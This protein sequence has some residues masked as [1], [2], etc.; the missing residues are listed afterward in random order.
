[1][2]SPYPLDMAANEVH[3]LR[4][5]GELFRLDASEIL[6]Q[7]GELTG[8][9][10]LDLCCGVG[11]V[12]D[13]LCEAVG[14]DGEVV[15]LD[16]DSAKLA[17]ARA[18][19]PAPNLV[20]IEGD[21]FAPPLEAASFDLVHSRFAMGIIPGGR[22]LFDVAVGLLRPGGVLFLEEGY[23]DT[24]ACHP[25][26]V[27]F[28]RGMAAMTRC[29]ELIGS[30]LRMGLDLPAMLRDA[31]M[32]EIALRPVS[33][34]IRAGDP[35]ADHMALTLEAMRATILDRGLMSEDELASTIA[36]ARMH[37]QH[38]GTVIHSFTMVQAVGRKGGMR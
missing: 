35:M 4:I 19:N 33:H 37:T 1:M 38:P 9:R 8:A 3:R 11:G 5:Q 22:A 34:L 14:P 10:V 6:S 32:Q 31:G 26:N 17:E 16:L 23:A 27:D 28:D 12:T 13:L 36:G 15:G 20:L 30:S 18:W 2:S 29:F 24:Y 25:P 7:I 21:A